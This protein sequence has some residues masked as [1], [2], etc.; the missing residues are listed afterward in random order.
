MNES[1]YFGALALMASIAP[2][3]FGSFHPF[4][5]KSLGYGLDGWD[6]ALVCETV[7]CGENGRLE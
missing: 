1:S 3:S 6:G 4:P 2:V 7:N 5:D